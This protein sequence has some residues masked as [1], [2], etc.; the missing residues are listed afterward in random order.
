MKTTARDIS[1][2]ILG[3][4]WKI[5][6]SCIAVIIGLKVLGFILLFY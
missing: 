4:F 1:N 6:V 5:V 3:G 2:G